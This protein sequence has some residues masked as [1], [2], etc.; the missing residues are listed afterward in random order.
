LTSP[1]LGIPVSGVI[2][3]R[4]LFCFET[5]SFYVALTVLEF[6]DYSPASASQMLGL[7]CVYT[8]K[9]GL[10]NRDLPST[11]GVQ[12]RGSAKSCI[13]GGFLYQCVSL[14]PSLA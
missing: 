7:K 9:A 3:S 8:T 10:S 12:P 11:F 2:S 1:C 4:V 14:W 6:S 13:W 5:L